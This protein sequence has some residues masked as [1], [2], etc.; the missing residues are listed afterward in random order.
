MAINAQPECFSWTYDLEIILRPEERRSLCFCNVRKGYCARQARAK[1]RKYK[2]VKK[3]SV[4]STYEKTHKKRR[5]EKEKEKAKFDCQID[6][7][8]FTIH[9]RIR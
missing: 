6:D 9:Q 3:K 1:N 4:K 8:R 2:A 7:A 5:K